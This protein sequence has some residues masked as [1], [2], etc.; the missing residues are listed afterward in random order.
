MEIKILHTGAEIIIVEVVTETKDS[1]TIR[2]PVNAFLN[3]QG[4]QVFLAPPVWDLAT[5]EKEFKI[6]KSRLFMEPLT[7][8]KD[9]EASYLQVTSKLVIPTSN[10]PPSSAGKG[11][12]KGLGKGPIGPG[13]G[14][15]I[16][17]S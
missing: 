4:G 3:P 2:K 14:P 17:K 15:I 1:L 11:P 12:G 13:K 6:S 8:L 16:V 9:L 10:V 5:V 7:P